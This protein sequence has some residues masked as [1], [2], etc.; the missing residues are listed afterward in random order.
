MGY[1]WTEYLKTGTAW[2]LAEESMGN[3][4]DT[5]AIPHST[6][7]QTKAGKPVHGAVSQE[8]GCLWG[9]K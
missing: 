9:W 4:R 5:P 1:F 6:I 8:S 7:K 3:H 2:F